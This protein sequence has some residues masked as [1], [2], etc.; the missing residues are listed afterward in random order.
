MLTPVFL[1]ALNRPRFA[2]EAERLQNSPQMGG[3][4]RKHVEIN[5]DPGAHLAFHTF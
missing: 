5:G 1:E 2:F 3:R 4:S